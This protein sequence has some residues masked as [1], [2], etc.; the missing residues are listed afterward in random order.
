[1]TADP[2]T[3]EEQRPADNGD[4]T[5]KVDEKHE[6]T[7][8]PLQVSRNVRNEDLLHFNSY[9]SIPIRR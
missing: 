7:V 8:D 9:S 5:N 1:M 3:K 2:T 4:S 6:Q